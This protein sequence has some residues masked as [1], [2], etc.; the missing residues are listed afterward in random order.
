MWV[1]LHV[2]SGVDHRA[3]RFI[4]CGMSDY[5][6]FWVKLMSADVIARSMLTVSIVRI[7]KVVG[8][9]SVGGMLNSRVL[10]ELM[11]KIM[12]IDMGRMQLMIMVNKFAVIELGIHIVRRI[13][14][15]H[16]VMIVS[17]MLEAQALIR[18]RRGCKLVELR[19]VM[20]IAI[21]RILVLNM[22]FVID[23]CLSMIRIGEEV[24]RLIIHLNLILLCIFAYISGSNSITQFGHLV[25]VNLAWEFIK[26]SMGVARALCVILRVRDKELIFKP[27]ILLALIEGAWDAKR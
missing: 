26:V 11:V 3:H 10:H 14:L 24:C 27:L 8:H 4:T 23:L 5:W 13:V 9:V 20:C 15:D 1:V 2:R 6:M 22:C 18:V 19:S 16:V 25:I 21:I 17:L 12:I 7:L